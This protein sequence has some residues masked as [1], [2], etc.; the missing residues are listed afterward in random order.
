MTARWA[1]AA[2]LTPPLAEHAFATVQEE[3]QR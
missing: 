3:Q 2:E 1:H